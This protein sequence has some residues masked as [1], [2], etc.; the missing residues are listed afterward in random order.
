MMIVGFTAKGEPVKVAETV[1]NKHVV[2]TGKSGMGKTV[3][4]NN[5]VA[6]L[7]REQKTVITLKLNK[8]PII[9]EDSNVNIINPAKDGLNLPILASDYNE[10]EQ[11]EKV[12]YISGLTEAL[13][14]SH[15]LGV[16]QIAALREAI[17]YSS[18]HREDVSDDMKAIETALRAQDTAV[19]LSVYDRLWDLFNIAVF[20]ESDKSIEKG[21]NNVIDFSDFSMNLQASCCELF[22]RSLWIRVKKIGYRGEEVIIYIDEFQRLT[23]NRKSIIPSMLCEARQFGIFFLLVTQTFERFSSGLRSSLEQAAIHVFFKPADSEIKKLEELLLY[24]SSEKMKVRFRN[25]KRGQ[26]IACGEF[27]VGIQKIDGPI[28]VRNRIE[29]HTNANGILIRNSSR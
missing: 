11:I 12:E 22:L 28:L 6:D 23:L 14:G 13:S 7:V 1:A 27:M 25:L 21:K 29:F 4:S 3:S 10:M 24:S 19:A 15:N 2:I 26:A 17:I 9:V 18:E 8:G 5:I 20:R 16:R